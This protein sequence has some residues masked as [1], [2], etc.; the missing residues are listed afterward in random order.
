MKRVLPLLLAAVLA[1]C[2]PPFNRP[3]FLATL[4]GQPEAEVVRRLGVPSRTYETNGRKFLAYS[5]Q[6]SELIEGGPAFG[7]FGYFGSGLG[8]YGAFPTEVIERGC[9]TTI[10]VGE[11]RMLAWTLRGNAC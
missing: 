3:A 8:Y 7:G 2:A 6:R 4:V 5:E 10:E 1:G 11:G 9:E